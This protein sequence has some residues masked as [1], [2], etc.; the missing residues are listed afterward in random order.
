MTSKHKNVDLC[1]A[2]NIVNTRLCDCGNT[3]SC[4]QSLYVY[5][6]KCNGTKPAVINEKSLQFIAPI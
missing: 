4:K 6:K 2:V 5:K 3:Y 1:L